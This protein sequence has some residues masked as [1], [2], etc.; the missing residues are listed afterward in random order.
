MSEVT[1]QSVDE[2]DIDT[3]LAEDI[4]FTGKLTFKDPLMIK[5]KLRGEINATGDLYIGE[6]A[7]VEAK[8]S[9]NMVSLKGKI[10]G[11]VVALASSLKCSVRS[12]WVG[13]P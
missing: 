13:I 1:I 2:A 9:A 11:N 10:T 4:D 8:V 6:D 5:G 7:V 3:I 12:S